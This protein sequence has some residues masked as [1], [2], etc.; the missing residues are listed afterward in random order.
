MKI[1]HSY[2]NGMSGIVRCEVPYEGIKFYIKQIHGDNA[3]L[4]TI[5]VAKFGS[6]FPHEVGELLLKNGHMY[7]CDIDC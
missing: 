4:D 7:Q 3:E 5:S 1:T 6:T 2:F